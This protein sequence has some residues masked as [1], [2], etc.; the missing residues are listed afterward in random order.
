MSQDQNTQSERRRYIRV[1]KNFILSY[2]DQR[3]PAT[4]HE[5]SQLKNIGL[6]GMCFVT[7]TWHQPGTRMF[8][9]LKTPYLAGTT[10][11]GGT[12]LGSHEKINTILY[13][14][15]LAF[16]PLSP[17]A[18]IVLNKIVAYFDKQGQKRD[19]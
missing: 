16:D 1:K 12:V 2:Y 8:I 3:D 14:T 18:E 10:S 7:S 11:L 15:R 4:K 17:Q 6:G 13:E 9:E 5:I 19:L